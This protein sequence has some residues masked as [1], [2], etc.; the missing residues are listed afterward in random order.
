MISL[1]FSF[2]FVFQVSLVLPSPQT[3][4]GGTLPPGEHYTGWLHS[5][6]HAVKLHRDLEQPASPTPVTHLCPA[7]GLRAPATPS[8]IS[9]DLS[10]EDVNIWSRESSSSSSCQQI[11]LQGSY[12]RQDALLWEPTLC[13]TAF[14]LNK[15]GT[16]FWD[17]SRQCDA[18]SEQCFCSIC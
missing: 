7:H 10:R 3:T 11:L 5:T 8:E 17:S 2:V 18:N 12:A 9:C 6:L 15:D 1:S 13:R 16:G 4:Q 14:R